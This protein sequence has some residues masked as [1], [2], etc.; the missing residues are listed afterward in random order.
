MPWKNTKYSVIYIDI[1]DVCEYNGQ[2]RNSSHLSKGPTMNTPAYWNPTYFKKGEA[3]VYGEFDGTIVRHYSE[4]MW[5][6][7]LPGGIACV[8]GADLTRKPVIWKPTKVECELIKKA[9]V[10]ESSPHSSRVTLEPGIRYN[11]EPGNDSKPESINIALVT[12]MTDGSW[13]DTD[14][15]EHTT[16]M[17]FKRG[18]ELTADGK[19]IV[20][21]YIYN[22]DGL[23]GNVIAN[24]EDGKLAS[25]RGCHSTGADYLPRLTA[26]Q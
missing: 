11:R 6:V 9:A 25:I 20:D 8:T 4:G 26:G 22:R 15:S 14:L 17:D 16:W 21:F 12:A 18:V 5:E 13:D 7:R 3:V 24:Y 1:I 2:H 10:M 23:L 19:A